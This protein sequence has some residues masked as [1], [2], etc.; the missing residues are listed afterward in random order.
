MT[1]NGFKGID[2]NHLTTQHGFL[3]SDSNPL[4]T[5]KASRIFWFKSTNDSKNFQNFDSNQLMT[6]KAFWDIDSNQ[7][8]TE[9]FES[10]VDFVDVF[11]AFTQFRWPFLGLSLNF[12]DIFWALKFL[13]SNPLMTQAVSIS[14]NWIES[15][16]HDSSGIPSIYS[17]WFMTQSASPF[18]DSN[19]LMTQ[20]KSIWF[21]VD[22]L[23]DSML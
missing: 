5:Q 8:M 18:F 16:H 12:V 13:D 1:H 20:G 7:V 14:K 21:W 2:S 11:R 4:T 23:F 6:Q 15:T 19:Q 3:K 9:W 22:S 17:D 10:I